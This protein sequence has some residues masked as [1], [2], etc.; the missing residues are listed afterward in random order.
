MKAD[1][2]DIDKDCLRSLINAE[3]G[4][5]ISVLTF[6]PCGE[7][8]YIYTAQNADNQPLF[9]RVQPFSK[10]KQLETA[11]A[12]TSLL[13][14]Y[15]GLK[16]VVAPYRTRHGNFTF[17]FKAYTVAVFPFIDGVTL[18]RQNVSE[19]EIRATARLLAQVHQQRLVYDSFM[20][21]HETFDNPFQAPIDQA[22]RVADRVPTSCNLYQRLA[23]QLL[24]AHRADILAMFGYMQ[25]LQGQTQALVRDWAL[26][27]GDPNRDNFLKAQDGT[28]YLTDWGELAIG[29]PERDL[30][31]WTG[32]TFEVFLRHYA[33]LRPTLTLHRTLFEFYF[34][35]WSL[36][37]IA[38]YAT[39][40][41]FR[42]LGAVENE[43]ALEELQNY[44]P[45][46]H[47]DI[48]ARLEQVE[49][50]IKQ[51]LG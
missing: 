30:V 51:V 5:R 18:Y 38:D 33:Q 31:H 21:P 42:E 4:L 19:D 46:R 48:A 45:V 39:Q 1:S 16:Q 14:N 13:H 28:L 25:W 3:Y 32:E 17:S 20:I 9:I 44:L 37:E 6:V 7:D 47:K 22:I 15:Y 40:I 36:Q 35:R 12:V 34:Y 2:S 27:H 24:I 23:C 11:Y 10:G 29:P 26:T 43:H 50:V 8:A 49:W 41:L